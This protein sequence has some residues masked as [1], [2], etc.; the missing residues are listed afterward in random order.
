MMKN[1]NLTV[2]FET[3]Q[4]ECALDY[5]CFT[6]RINEVIERGEDGFFK[7]N[8]GMIMNRTMADTWANNIAKMINS[9]HWC[10]VTFFSQDIEY[11]VGFD[12]ITGIKY[13]FSYSIE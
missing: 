10:E 2:I 6:S 9:K 8:V 5:D 7:V 4:H 13:H 12:D 1:K 11:G 3:Y